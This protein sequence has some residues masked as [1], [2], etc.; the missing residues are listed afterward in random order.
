MNEGQNNTELPK[1]ELK[2]GDELFGFKLMDISPLPEY[3]ALGI[4]AQHRA[5]GAEVFHLLN[6]DEENLFCFGFQTA[7]QDSTGVAH[8]LEHAVLCGSKKY[9]L[10]DSFITLAQGSLQTFLN[11]MTYPDKTLYPGST[12]NRQDYFNMMSVYGDA[13]F[14]PLLPKWVFDQE[15]WRMEV[16]AQEQVSINGIVYNEMKG[17]YS[18]AESIAGDLAKSLILPSGPY[19][20]DSGGN[21]D[22]IPQLTH[23]DLL[24]FHK[25]YYC[26]AN[27]R[28]F[29]CGNIDTAEQLR[30]LDREFFAQLPAGKPAPPIGLEP[31]WSTPKRFSLPAPGEETSGSI[32]IISWLLGDVSDVDERLLYQ[33]LGE[34]LLGHEGSPL[35]RALVDSQ[36]GEDLAPV[37]GSQSG[38]R[39]GVFSVSL[40]GVP[41]ERIGEFEE[42]VFSTLQKLV[43]EGISAKDIQATLSRIEFSNR[44][45]QRAGGPYSLVHMNRSYAAWLHGRHPSS[46]LRVQPAL[47]RLRQRLAQNEGFLEEQIKKLFLENSHHAFIE[48]Q[49]KKGYSEEVEKKRLKAINLRYA[50]LRPEEK[51]DIKKAE[52]AL[53]LA[54]SKVESD[55]ER[56]CIPH[57]TTEDLSPVY[58]KQA[59]ELS[60]GQGLPIAMSPVHT[61]GISYVNL[62]L[63]L[64]RVAVEDY[65][66]LPLFSRFLTAVSVGDLDYGQVATQRTQL[67]GNFFTYASSSQPL[68][69]APQS[70]AFPSGIFDVGNR[71]FFY[72]RMSFLDENT[73]QALAFARQSLELAC[74]DDKKRLNDILLEAKNN[75]EQSLAMNGGHWAYLRASKRIT[76]SKAIGEIWSGLSQR[77]FINQLSQI[78]EG[79][80]KAKVAHSSLKNIGDFSSIVVKLNS[81]RKAIF[82]AGLL[83]HLVG[84]KKQCTKLKQAI[85]QNFADLGPPR[86]RDTAKYQE[87]IWQNL[88]YDNKSQDEVYVSP[89]SQTSFS[90]FLFPAS[91]VGQKSFAA[92]LVLANYLSTVVF[93]EEIRMKGGAYGA[94]AYTSGIDALFSCSSYRDPDPARSIGVFKSAL[95]TLAQRPLSSAELEKTIIGAY[96]SETGPKTPRAQAFGTFVRRINGISPEIRDKKLLDMLNLSPE[97]LRQAAQNLLKAIDSA[98]YAVFTTPGQAEEIGSALELLPKEV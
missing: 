92:E 66:W 23:K 76:R 48:V 22:N 64:D 33:F 31:R 56:A 29:L 24:D 47:A 4:Y 83:A 51:S 74:F 16:D 15:A 69:G 79:E 55:S 3:Q 95:D 44:E 96:S 42:L 32:A 50:A 28:I 39:E 57:L 78:F 54:Q 77:N 46:T 35:A 86:P 65:Y 59:F 93:W 81:L 60:E 13:V 37:N 20:H 73:D 26:P 21:P 11:A 87:E 34:L 18:S 84:E 41:Q 9:P 2:I 14:N 52:E 38:L 91:V 70:L 40:R 98:N 17:N 6:T 8:I 36:I 88:I 97:E 43:S 90:A 61:N 80:G 25:K 5:S 75:S 94:W 62:L 10:K 71:D 1:N 68:P 72:I 7:P 19:R 49:G 30:F 53:H 85:V 58:P 89:K 63:P 67:Y 27:C 12:I 82:D 45:I